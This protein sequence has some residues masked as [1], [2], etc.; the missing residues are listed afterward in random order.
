MRDC[1]KIWLKKLESARA[2][3]ARKTLAGS[4]KK[5]RERDKDS[6]QEGNNR[7]S[8][9]PAAGSREGNLCTTCTPDKNTR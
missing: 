6:D 9:R 8:G 3:I 2:V 4:G 1:M 7:D 5:R